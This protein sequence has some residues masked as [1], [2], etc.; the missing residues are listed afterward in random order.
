MLETVAAAG[1]FDSVSARSSESDAVDRILEGH[2]TDLEDGHR[3]VFAILLAGMADSTPADLRSDAWVIRQNALR[4]LAALSEFLDHFSGPRAANLACRIE[5]RVEHGVSREAVALTAID[6]VG[7]GRAE[8]LAD[9]GLT[10]PAAVVDA[11]ADGLSNAGMSDSVAERIV[12]AARECPRIEV[13]WGAFPET[14]AVGENELCEVA[15]STAG[16][17]ARV[18]IRVT[19]NDVEMTETATYLD[20]ETTTPVGVFGPSDADELQFVVE[21]VFPDL[22]LMPVRATRAVRVE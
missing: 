3:K 6:G 15:V 10:S 22:P 5:A 11:G 12:E 4:L 21:V 1:E 9:A 20:G 8:R 17:G 14:V 16:G 19:V 18:G 2:D 13:D 7:S